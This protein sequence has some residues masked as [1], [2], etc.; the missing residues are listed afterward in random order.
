MTQ[1]KTSRD[2]FFSRD[3]SPW[4][5]MLMPAG[6][7]IAGLA[8]M[9][10]LVFLF[11]P[12]S[13]GQSR[14]AAVETEWLLWNQPARQSLCPDAP[15]FAWV[16][17]EKG[18]ECIRYFPGE[19][20]AGADV[21]IVQFY[22]DRDRVMDQPPEKIRNNTRQSQE[23]Y[24]AAQSR[25][26]G[27]PVV[28]VA[29]P[30]TY[31]SSGDHGLR[32]Q[33]GEFYTLKAALTFIRD[34][35]GINEVILMGHSGGATAAA[36]LLTLGQTH[37]RCAVLSSGAYSLLTRAAMQRAAAGK[38]PRPGRDTTGLANPYDPLDHISG[39]PHDP[40]RLIII[41]GN[42]RDSVTPFELQKAFA[43]ALEAAGHRVQV[44][45]HPAKEPSYHNLLGNVAVETAAGCGQR[46]E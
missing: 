26:A 13:N 32:R 40:K 25:R 18:S 35:Y 10:L 42:E 20:L 8:G 45:E 1:K 16:S 37:V 36:A 21:V 4:R 3:V 46:S 5:V 15:G 28:V 11:W 33:A 7:G 9:A 30:G 41:L 6:I 44:T 22:G 43:Q 27:L 24:A 39:I 23:G 34:R 14:Q 31:G 12:V 38:P 17:H 29:R 2:H 19:N